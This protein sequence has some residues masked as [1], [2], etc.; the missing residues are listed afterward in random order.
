MNA[1]QTLCKMSMQCNENDLK[2]AYL[3]YVSHINTKHIKHMKLIISHTTRRVQRGSIYRL[4]VSGAKYER[5][6]IFLT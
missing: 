6:C 4:L 3:N 5:M 2:H 1:R